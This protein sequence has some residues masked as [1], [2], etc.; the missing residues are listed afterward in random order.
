MKMNKSN[1]AIQFYKWSYGYKDSELDT[2]FCSFFWKFIVA[3]ILSPITVFSL[4]VQ[5]AISEFKD[6]GEWR[7]YGRIVP[8]VFIASAVY[9]VIFVVT[10]AI[11]YPVAFFSVL[12]VL[13]L[14][15]GIAYH[16]FFKKN[17]FVS[18]TGKIIKEKV[19]SAKE[20]YCPRITWD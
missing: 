10:V 15:L 20:G 5:S 11:T 7:I 17:E 12:L 1:K 13:L 19:K 3:L 9:L 14:L 18:D 6:N 4:P 2:N 8:F 16:M